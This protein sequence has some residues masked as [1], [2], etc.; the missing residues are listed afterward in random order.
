MAFSSSTVLLKVSQVP[1]WERSAIR[2]SLGLV[3][4]TSLGLTLWAVP[5]Q[6]EWGDEVVQ[7]CN[8]AGATC[9]VVAASPL[10]GKV[11]QLSYERT[12]GTLTGGMLGFLVY[13]YGIRLLPDGVDHVFMVCCAAVVGFVSCWLSNRFKLDASMR[14]FVITFLIVTFGANSK[15]SKSALGVALLRTGGI[16][17]GVLL[18]MGLTIFVLPKSATIESLR[19]LKNGLK[20]LTELN[21]LVWTCKQ[22]AAE[23]LKQAAATARAAAA[24]AASAAATA[25]RAAAASQPDGCQEPPP[26]VAAG[27]DYSKAAP[28]GWLSGLFGRWKMWRGSSSSSSNGYLPLPEADPEAGLMTAAAAAAA[29]HQAHAARAADAAAAAATQAAAAASS[30]GSSSRPA[31]KAGNGR[32]SQLT[33][34]L[35]HSTSSSAAG[36]RSTAQAQHQW[37]TQCCRCQA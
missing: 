14:L 37:S 4:F 22:E 24:E 36:T 7:S 10:I 33:Q 31:G 29:A 27:A 30:A 15:D 28:K 16:V 1:D 2:L 13:D 6:E 32:V 8:W 11:A 35:Q 19:E 18:I 34:A 17:C 12:L 26:C 20:L 21:I 3:F 23:Q 5:V 9:A 25:A